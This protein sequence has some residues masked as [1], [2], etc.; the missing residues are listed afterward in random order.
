MKEVDVVE[1][2][3]V[4]L[5]CTTSSTCKRSCLVVFITV[6]FAVI[7]ILAFTLKN[8][9]PRKGK[10]FDENSNW[11]SLPDRMERLNENPVYA[12][13]NITRQQIRPRVNLL[14]VV[15]SAPNRGGRRLA[16]RE[17]WWNQSRASDKVK[18][19]CCYHLSQI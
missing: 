8:I 15:S 19:Q 10:T 18:M 6:Q 12:K 7:C 3:P 4:Q 16:I 11:K 17:T 2:D 14:I 9:M 1:C 5:R 13:F